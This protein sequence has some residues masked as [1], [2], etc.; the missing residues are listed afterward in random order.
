MEDPI[1]RQINSVQKLRARTELESE[2]RANSP[3]KEMQ[4]M[5][6]KN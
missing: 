3:L 1:G 5:L 2:Q 4:E 6:K